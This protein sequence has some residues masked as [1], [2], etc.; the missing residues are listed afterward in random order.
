MRRVRAIA[1]R[2][3]CN[4]PD[5]AEAMFLGAISTELKILATRHDDRQLGLKFGLMNSASFS[6]LSALASSSILSMPRSFSA[7]YN[8]VIAKP[9]RD[10]HGGSY[11]YTRFVLQE[12]RFAFISFGCAS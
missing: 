5:N 7:F 9:I 4:K 10:A 2:S 6:L 1:L 3:L 8:G 12:E 11:S